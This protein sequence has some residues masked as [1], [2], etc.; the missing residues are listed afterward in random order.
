MNK[1]DQIPFFPISTDQ[2]QYLYRVIQ[3]LCDM[4]FLTHLVL[5]DFAHRYS[6]PMYV[7]AR[8]T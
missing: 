4:L 1:S 8:L 2:L 5:I 6:K 7:E 3:V